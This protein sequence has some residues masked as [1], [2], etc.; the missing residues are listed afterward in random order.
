VH[1]ELGRD[2]EKRRM[3]YEFRS[4]DCRSRA[5]TLLIAKFIH[6]D[7]GSAASQSLLKK[8]VDECGVSPA[9]P[10]SA[11]GN[12]N[13]LV[14][15][16]IVALALALRLYQIR[17]ESLWTDER[18]NLGD[19]IIWEFLIA[20]SSV[21]SGRAGV[22]RRDRILSSIRRRYFQGITSTCPRVYHSSAT[23]LLIPSRSLLRTRM[24]VDFFDP[25]SAEV[26]PPVGNALNSST[27]TPN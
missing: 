3:L 9:P 12:R 19:P 2:I 10:H 18:L 27:A 6:Q 1:A 17:S 14:I 24:L 23:K 11:G 26:V 4:T 7:L 22:P 25:G 15:G 13:W 5:K 21:L 16:G 8:H 20:S